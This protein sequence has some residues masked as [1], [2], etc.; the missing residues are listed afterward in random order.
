MD[1][2]LERLSLLPFRRTQAE[3]ISRPKSF[4]PG[5]CE[6]RGSSTYARLAPVVMYILAR[7]MSHLSSNF[8]PSQAEKTAFNSGS[9]RP[10]TTAS[11]TFGGRMTAIGDR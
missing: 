9:E 1:S 10:G 6:T 11:R 8:V 5:S 3:P 7:A 4:S 2:A